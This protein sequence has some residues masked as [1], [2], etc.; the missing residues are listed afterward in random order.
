MTM[1]QMIQ[2]GTAQQ[3][4]A[5]RSERPEVPAWRALAYVSGDYPDAQNIDQVMGR[6][7]WATSGEDDR[8]YCLNC[9]AD[10]DG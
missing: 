9:G 2:D 8:C 6:H 7:E 4:F 10:G 3:Y 1:L 5:L